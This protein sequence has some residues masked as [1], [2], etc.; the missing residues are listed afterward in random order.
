MVLPPTVL[1]FYILLLARK[2]RSD[3]SGCPDRPTLAFSFT[4]LV[5]ACY[6][7]MPFVVQRFSRRLNSLIKAC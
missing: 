2:L 4:G 5:I 3:S 7:L 6:L 1:G